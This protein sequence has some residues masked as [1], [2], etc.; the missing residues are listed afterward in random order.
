VIS[1]SADESRPTILVVEDDADISDVVATSLEDQ[2]YEVVLAANGQEALDKLRDGSPTPDLIL[3]DLMMPVMDGFEFREEQRSDPA[4][5]SIPVVL[6][7][8]HADLRNTAAQLD[9]VEWLK[10]PVELAT[11]LSVVARNS[12]NR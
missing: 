9:A 3:L 8:A 2:G 1:T 10:K 12:R 11:L 4:I 7:S 6:F 5:A